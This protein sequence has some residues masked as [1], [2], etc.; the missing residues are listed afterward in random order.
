MKLRLAVL[1]PGQ[2]HGEGDVVLDKNYTS[3]LRCIEQDSELFIM[4]RDDFLHLFKQ[5]EA[6]WRIMYQD[7][8]AKEQ[9][10]INAW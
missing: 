3:T 5:N 6:A 2:I 8:M 10:N 1:G 7:A 4:N 9:Q